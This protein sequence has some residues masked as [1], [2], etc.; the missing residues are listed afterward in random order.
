MSEP[1]GKTA[2]KPV[3]GWLPLVYFVIQVIVGVW[4]AFWL[5]YNHQPQTGD[6]IEHLHSAWLVHEGKIPYID[7][8]QHHNPLL[9]YLFSPLAGYFA[10]DLVL[11]DVVRIISTVVMFASLYV[12]A[13][14]VKRFMAGNWY[15]GVLCIASVFPSYVI[16]SGQDFRPDNYMV[17][18]FM[19]GLYWFFAYLERRQLR[20]LVL[21]FMAMFTAFLFMQKVI[22]LLAFFAAVF[23]YQLYVGRISVRDFLKALI[24]PCIGGI[25]FLAW[26]LAHDMVGRY[27]LANYIFNLHIPDVY[28][29]LVEKTK[30]E[31][32]VVSAL[33]LCGC[34]YSLYRGN[35]YARIICL[36]WVFEALQRFFYFSLDRHYYYQLQI[37]NGML[38][39]T[40]A[41]EIIKKWRIAAYVFAVL[42]LSGCL[43]FKNYCLENRLKPY[44]HRYVTPKYVLE[45]TNR[46]DVVINGYGLTYGIFSKDVTYYWNLN[47]QLDVIGSKIGLA[48]LPDLNGAVQKYLPRIIYTGPYWN[49]RLRKKHIDVPVH[50]IDKKLRDKYYNQS[51]FVD[52]FILKP[53]YQAQ[54]RCRYNVETGSWDYYY[55]E[56]YNKEE[57]VGR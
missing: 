49:E 6:D 53:E 20:D 16:F 36:L 7:F 30:P 50:W 43:V 35:I 5:L 40:F 23:F 56:N 47:G 10:Y 33:A 27:W 38:A 42:S 44:Y 1:A 8:F 17:L 2:L 48:P 15:A 12:A 24:L 31:F 29:G 34:I 45:Q 28:G 3:Y 54:R 46:C 57:T 13:L 37:F 26:L 25:V 18:M 21:S 51:A 14:I 55:K 9:W 22:F 32:Y 41:W 11:F 39:G 4:L 19:L 52:I